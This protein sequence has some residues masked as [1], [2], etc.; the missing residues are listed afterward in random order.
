[1]RLIVV[2]I[3]ESTKA[4]SDSRMH[5][6]RERIPFYGTGTLRERKMN[7]KGTQNG[8]QRECIFFSK[9]QIGMLRERIFFSVPC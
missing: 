4:A 1:M 3:S 9:M 7:A 6:A 2:H 8:T 5:T